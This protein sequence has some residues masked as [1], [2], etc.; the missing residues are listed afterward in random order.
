MI[1]RPEGL[2]GEREIFTR[3]RPKPAPAPTPPAGPRP[4]EDLGAD[5]TELDK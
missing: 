1:L 5:K 2:F 4:G 3:S